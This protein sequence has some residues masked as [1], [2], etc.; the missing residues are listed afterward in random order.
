MNERKAHW[1]NRRRVAQIGVPTLLVA[2]IIAFKAQAHMLQVNLQPRQAAATAMIA[3]T[4]ADKPAASTP[5]SRETQPGDV[6]TDG[7]KS[8]IE[9]GLSYGGERLELFGTLGET[10]ADAVIV[11]ITSPAETIKLNQKGRVGPFWMSVKQHTVD[12]VP[13]MYHINASDKIESL[14][15]AD[16]RLSL[17]IGFE[18]IRKGMK[19]ETTKGTADPAD[20]Q[21]IFD[22]LMQLKKDQDLYL[23]NDE[24]RVSIKQGRLFKHGVDFPSASKEGKYLVETFVF[25]QG[26]LV[27]RAIDTIS[28]RKVGLGA[29]IVR[30]SNDYPKTYG[31]CAVVI[32]LS[33]GLLV[34]F[35]FRKGGHH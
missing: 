18:S 29:N 23:V 2:G 30:W 33:A 22:G 6:V 32:A 1:L 21:T 4:A 34:G 25:R 24:N 15:S 31:L 3:A 10:Q 28:I 20:E 12:N 5:S 27:G 11:K 19:I 13:F 14:L 7:S 16:Q 8:E 26:N 35:V 17:G 9:I